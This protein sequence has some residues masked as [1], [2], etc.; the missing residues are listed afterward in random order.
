[1]A[2]R[3]GKVAFYADLVYDHPHSPAYWIPPAY[4]DVEAILLGGDIHYLP[5]HLGA[6]LN[7]IRKTQHDDTLLI[8]VP[9]NGEYVNQELG[10]ARREYRAAVD[11]VPG[12]VFLDDD[13][14]ELPSGLRVI[15]STLWSHV[16]GDQIEPYNKLLADNG[17]DGDNIRLADHLMT[18]QDT[19]ELHGQARSFLERQLRGLSRVER[20]K[21]VVCTHFW[22]TLRPLT[23]PDGQPLAERHIIGSDLD[24][25]IAECG[26][27]LWLCGHA[28]TSYH[29]TIGTTEI[30]SNPRAGDGP[31]HVNPGFAEDYVVTL[32][33]TAERPPY[34]SGTSWSRRRVR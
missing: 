3:P 22:P 14:V 7:D 13:V 2:S 12:A 1:M 17:M 28:H 33:S 31:G 30:S 6:M 5:R 21:T 32:A 18:L 29:V 15:G 34:Q 23:G 9:G 20:E 19:N 24:A 4:L 27:G 8:V 16:P 10:E 25:L 26:P 11:A